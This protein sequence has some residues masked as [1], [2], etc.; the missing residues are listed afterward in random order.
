MGSIINTFIRIRCKSS[1]GLTA[2]TEIKI[3]LMD[4]RHCLFYGM[5]GKRKR[6][7]FIIFLFLI[8]LPPSLS[9]LSFHLFPPS[10]HPLSLPLSHPPFPSL[11]LS[12]LYPGTLDG[13][14][15]YV[16]TVPEKVYRRLSM[17]QIKLTQGVRHVAGLNPKC[18]RYVYRHYYKHVCT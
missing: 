3:A 4:K 1:A 17:L 11:P 14:L 18:H 2:S 5:I 13:G 8:P 10:F 15:G 7:D 16:I 12:P 6:M 9:P